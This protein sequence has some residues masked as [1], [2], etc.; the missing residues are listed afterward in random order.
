MGFRNPLTAATSVNTA[1]GPG[2]G[3]VSLYSQTTSGGGG[4]PLVSGVV[5]FDDGFPGDVHAT[6]TRSAQQQRSDLIGSASG[7]LSIDG[8][9]V[10]GGRL[11]KLDLSVLDPNAATTG[12]DA[13]LYV[14]GGTLTRFR[15][16]APVEALA[17]VLPALILAGLANPPTGLLGGSMPDDSQ[18]IIYVGSEVLTVNV[19]SFSALS[20]PAFPHG[21]LTVIP[22]PGDIAGGLGQ[23]TVSAYRLTGCDVRL[24]GTTGGSLA[25]GANVRVNFAAVGW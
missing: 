22:V 15:V 5:D 10:G 18:P 12:T 2:T 24:L 16:A 20:W 13:H 19:A 3:G 7:T 6:I 23:V 17:G 11:P 25:N 1:A 4:A 21:V 8:G 14:P 9:S